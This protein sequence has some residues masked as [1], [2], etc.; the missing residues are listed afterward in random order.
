MEELT[1]LC[2]KKTPAECKNITKRVLKQGGSNLVWV[3][4][5]LLD[6]KKTAQIYSSEIA[7]KID[8][9]LQEAATI[10]AAV[11]AKRKEAAQKIFTYWSTKRAEIVD[12]KHQ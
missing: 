2:Y 7:G 12:K 8:A 9:Q 1:Q 3:T 6:P 10:E 11:L 5:G 4:V